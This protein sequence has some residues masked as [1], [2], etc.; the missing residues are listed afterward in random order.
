MSVSHPVARTAFYCCALRADDAAA[1][2]PVCGDTFAARFLDDE[3]RRAM[4]PL[5][6]LSA[7]AASNV[8]RHRLIDDLIRARLAEDA[9]RRVFLIG[10]GFDTRAF[11]MEGGRWLEIDEPGLLAY[12]EELLPARDAPNPLA[13]VAVSLE[14]GALPRQL[15]PLGGDDPALVIVE[16]V[17]MYL[18]DAELEALARAVRAALP[19]ATLICDL[20]TLGFAETFSRPLRR[21]LARQG[22]TFGRRWVHPRKLVER[23]GYALREQHSIPGRALEAGTLSMP[24][25][26]FNSALRGLRDGYAVYV[27]EPA[28]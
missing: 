6:R 26:L 25:W 18:G 1:E 28:D 11:R 12:K 27:F 16:G 7:P 2:R 24:P 8:A 17:S 9:G 10:A 14:G 4:E 13:R 15:T 20:M 21:E 23:A 5:L 19:R 3:T 22:A